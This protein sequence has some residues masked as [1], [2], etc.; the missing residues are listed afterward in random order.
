[1]KAVLAAAATAVSNDVRPILADDNSELNAVIRRV[2][3][4]F[5]PH[6]A[7]FD[8][9]DPEMDDICAAYQSPTSAFFVAERQGRVVGGAGVGPL[10]GREGAVCEL[11]KM[12]LLPEARRVR[13]GTELALRC[14]E[15][16]RQMG[17]KTC[18]LRTLKRMNAAQTLYLSLGFR[19]LRTTEVEFGH[20]DFTWFQL[21][22][23]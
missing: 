18:F 16:A 12:Y 21:D 2:R 23:G 15:A 6:E 3:D 9:T 22:L 1:M 19:P 13:L 20:Q 4:S 10:A 8:A 11:R 5:G 17:Y 14:L 7:G